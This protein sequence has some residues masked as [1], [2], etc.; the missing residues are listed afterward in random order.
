MEQLAGNRRLFVD[1]FEHEMGV[2]AFLGGFHAFVYDFRLALDAA[3]ITHPVQLGVI[4][5][6]HDDLSVVDPDDRAREGQDRRQVRGDA[7]GIL[8]DPDHQAPNPF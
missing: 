8:R 2:A 3:A 7:G 1:L 4:R 5:V 6:K